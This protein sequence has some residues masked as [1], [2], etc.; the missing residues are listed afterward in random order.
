MLSL[1]IGSAATRH[2]LAPLNRRVRLP[3]VVPHLTGT[4]LETSNALRFRGPGL[5][6]ESVTVRIVPTVKV[7]ALSRHFVCEARCVN[8]QRSYNHKVPR[9]HAWLAVVLRGVAR[10]SV[11][12]PSP[13][14]LAG[15]RRC[16][17]GEAPKPAGP[18]RSPS[19]HAVTKR[20]TSV[21]W[22]GGS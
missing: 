14:E 8:R 22:G 17:A 20:L 21:E 6:A 16:V 13:I 4:A 15:F 7:S 5:E 2:I 12:A 1:V 3:I 19:I 10:S 18:Q 11:S 9:S